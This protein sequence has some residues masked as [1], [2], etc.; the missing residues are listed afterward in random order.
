ML[1]P[2]EIVPMA[3]DFNDLHAT[4]WANSLFSESI[5]AMYPHVVMLYWFQKNAKCK[6]Q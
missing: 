3:S 5:G 4:I 2:M 1:P 6:N